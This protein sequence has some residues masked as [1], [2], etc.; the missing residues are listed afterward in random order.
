M[1]GIDERMDFTGLIPRNKPKKKKTERN[2][3][4]VVTQIPKKLKKEF[5]EIC[6]KEGV[7]MYS[8]IS[9]FIKYY[10]EHHKKRV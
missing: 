3:E 4:P 7:S 1:E 6:E 8:V 2:F 9:G 10:V 5:K